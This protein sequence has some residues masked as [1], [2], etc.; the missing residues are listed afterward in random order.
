M[1]ETARYVALDMESREFWNGRIK[2]ILYGTAIVASVLVLSK[3][4]T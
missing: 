2:R 4:H 3:S 1:P